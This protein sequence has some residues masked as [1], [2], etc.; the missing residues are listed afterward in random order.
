VEDLGFCR[1]DILS[2]KE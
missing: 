1:T 2:T